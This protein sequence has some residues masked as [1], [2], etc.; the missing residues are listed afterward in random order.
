MLTGCNNSALTRKE[1]DDKYIFFYQRWQELLYNRTQDMH[2]YNLLNSCTACQELSDV[3]DKTI[4]GLLTS[5]QNVD[6]IKA[7]CLFILKQDDILP[8]YNLPL[9][10]ALLRIVASKIEAKQKQ[11]SIEDKN[12]TFY[13]SLIRLKH[14][15]ATPVRLLKTEYLNYVLTAIK[16]GIDNQNQAQIEKHILFLISE[17][18]YQGWSAKGLFLLSKC[19]EGSDSAKNKWT[20][21]ASEFTL[22]RKKSFE[23]YYG[24]KIE[25]RPGISVND[26]KSIIQSLGMTV[27]KGSEVIDDNIGRNNLYT[28]LDAEKYYIIVSISSFDM[29]SATISVIN[30]L[31]KKLSVAAFYNAINPW[32]A[33]APQIVV[34][35]EN[36]SLAESLKITD[37][38]KT[39]DY[40]DSTNNVFEDTKNILTNTSKTL[41]MNRLHAAFSYTNLSRTSL[42]QETKYISLWIAIESVMRTGQ[43]PDIISHIKY[44]LP[45]ILSVRYI[46]RIIRNFSEDCI[47]CGFK[48]EASL[49]IDMEA[50]DKKQLVTMLIAIFR[51]SAKYT[52]FEQRCRTNKLLLHRCTEIHVFLNSNDLIVEKLEHYASKIRWHIQRLYRIRN[53]ITHSAFQEDKSLTIY[54]EHLYT[55]LSQ[56]I[57][58]VVYYIE[59]KQV[60]SIE[61]AFS[62]ILEN[63]KT[64]VELIKAGQIKND[65]AL[66]N[67]I[68]DILS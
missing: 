2:Q 34:F 52:F 35:C 42:F 41:I 40:V 10:N 19:F 38:F 37:V 15:L 20:V 51:D 58:E 46:Y 47:R 64:F 21:F 59:H 45:E 7:E 13:T 62:T 66:T 44:V 12:S 26:V 55:Y 61:E 68:I 18:I 28:K 54:I 16:Y 27:K 23:I 29:Y 53:E 11:E 57:S 31:N 48:K 60:N 24:I 30:Q 8:K 9:Y 39:Y 65:A 32:I 49:N 63:Y 36:S 17:C 6:D 3:I 14:Q 33:N 56:L 1:V 67:G 25:T 22:S 5:R 43:Y 4:S 50:S